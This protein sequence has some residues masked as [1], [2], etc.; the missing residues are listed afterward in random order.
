MGLGTKE[1]SLP[2]CTSPCKKFNLKSTS[3]S[4]WGFINSNHHSPP[5]NYRSQ[6][7][8]DPYK[9]NFP[10]ITDV[11][12]KTQPNKIKQIKKLLE[13]SLSSSFIPKVNSFGEGI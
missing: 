13:Q 8:I 9:D 4:N 3:T 12:L 5:N 1:I 10:I 11:G 2:L 6:P 7:F